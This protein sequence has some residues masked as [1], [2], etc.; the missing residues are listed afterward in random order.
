[1]TRKGRARAAP[2]AKEPLPPPLPPETR[3]VG[4]LVAETIRF[5]GRRFWPS[6]ALGLA[7]A[8]LAVASTFL[9]RWGQF[10]VYE[11]GGALLF[12]ASYVAGCALVADATVSRQRLAT[13]WL[14]GVLIWIPFPFLALGIILPG[15]AWL[16]LVGLAVPAAVVEGAPLRAALGRGI[17]LGRADYVHSLGSLAT[18][19]IVVGATTFLLSL[20]IHTGSDQAIRVAVFLSNLVVSPVVF[21]GAALLYYDQ[22]ARAEARK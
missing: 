15:V 5:Y 12:S 18:L 2:R 3:T 21:L 6:L 17:R 9:D 10:V 19:V 11:T 4:Q 22:A 1:M 8:G 7:P 13:A 20:L 16:A 14:A